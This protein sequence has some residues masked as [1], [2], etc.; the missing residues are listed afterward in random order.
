V[1]WE[2]LSPKDRQVAELLLLGHGNKEI[3]KKL[4]MALRTVKAH[5]N[6]MFLKAGVTDEKKIPRIRL[7]VMLTYERYPSLRPNGKFSKHRADDDVTDNPYFRHVP[8]ECLNDRELRYLCSVGLGFRGRPKYGRRN[9][10]NA[11]V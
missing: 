4:G 3:G 11:H 9:V 1:L 5:M 10:G 8:V 2:K 6:K 7:A